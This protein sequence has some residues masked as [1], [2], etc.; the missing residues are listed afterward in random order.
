MSDA[1]IL[2]FTTVKISTF[3]C[4]SQR[5]RMVFVGRNSLMQTR[6]ECFSLR[7]AN[8]GQSTLAIPYDCSRPGTVS[9]RLRSE[10]CYCS[11]SEQTRLLASYIHCSLRRRSATK[12]DAASVQ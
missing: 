6:T 11:M 9:D 2:A 3:D 1:I 8:T 4:D 10:L 7:L 5:I 12:A